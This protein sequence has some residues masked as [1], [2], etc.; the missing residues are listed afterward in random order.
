[1]ARRRSRAQRTG[2][3]ITIGAITAL[4]LIAGATVFVMTRDDS[5]VSAGDDVAAAGVRAGAGPAAATGAFFKRVGDSWK[6]AERIEAL[7]K[8]NRDLRQWRETSMALAERLERYEALL[9]MPSEAFGVGAQRDRTISA[10]LILD[11]GGPFKRTL[12]ANAGA[13]HGVERGYIALNENGLIGRVVAVGRRS[14]RVLILDDFNS[15]IPVMGLQSR[16]RAMLSGDASLAPRIE[17][18]AAEINSP[19]LEY[20]APSGALREGERIVTSGDGG[21]FPRGLLVGAATRDGQGLWRVK[22]SVSEHPIDY[23]RLMPFAPITAPEGAL[24]PDA[25]PPIPIAS[26]VPGP[27]ASLPLTAP[28]PRPRV[29][30]LAPVAPSVAD[31]GDDAPPVP[32]ATPAPAPA[33]PPASTA[34]PQ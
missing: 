11:A 31:G 18:G 10:R 34:P 23:V 20:Q 19:R 12:L 1:V 29:R 30:P 5:G 25:G 8:E 15:K 13:D 7:E 32:D 24:V 17:T 14:S 3:R 16:A 4:V 26:G 6:A 21:V 22:L 28:P 2:V 27:V 9:K 33:P